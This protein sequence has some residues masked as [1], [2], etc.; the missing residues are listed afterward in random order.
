MSKHY[1]ICFRLLIAGIACTNSYPTK[2]IKVEA[3]PA[4]EYVYVH[5]S[6]PDAKPIARKD[7]TT[8][9]SQTFHTSHKVPDSFKYTLNK[10]EKKVNVWKETADSHNKKK[11]KR[12]AQKSPAPAPAGAIKL[13]IQKLL[14]Q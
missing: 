10:N 14:A 1:S 6:A 3:Q 9:E 5:S 8:Q 12:E 11:Y 4:D 7:K 2:E 13:D